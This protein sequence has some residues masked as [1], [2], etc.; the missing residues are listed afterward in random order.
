VEALALHATVGSGVGEAV[1][2]Q[3][4]ADRRPEQRLDL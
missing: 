1:V 4:V 3:L 2:E